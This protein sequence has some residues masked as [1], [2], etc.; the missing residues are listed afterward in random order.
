MPSHPERVRRNYEEPRKP[1]TLEQTKQRIMARC[2]EI[3]DAN[4]LSLATRQG[5]TLISGQRTG[6]E[7]V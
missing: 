5:G 7:T 3:A 1:L 4:M 6:D 2:L